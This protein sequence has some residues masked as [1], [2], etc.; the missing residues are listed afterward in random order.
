MV[1]GLLIWTGRARVSNKVIIG[2]RGSKLALIQADSVA[3]KIREIRPD[4][5]VIISKVV[6][7]GDRNPRARLD[8]M[9]GVGVFVKELEEALLS[10]KIDLAVHSLK[11]MPT[12]TPQ[13][14]CLAAITERADP[15]DV[16]VCGA[17]SLAGMPA[18]S[19]IGTGSPRR[20][21]QLVRYR[22]DLE[23]RSIRGNIDTRL[24]KVSHGDYDGVIIAAAAMLRLG[25]QDRISEYLPP[26]Y[27]LPAVGQGALV[28]EARLGDEELL[29]IA[30]ALNHLSAWQSACAERAFLSVLGGGCRAPIAAL[31]TV[32]EDSLQI[33]GMVADTSGAEM[34]RASEKGKA[35]SAEE[36][37]AKLAHEMLAMGAS[38]LI[39]EVKA[40]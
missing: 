9:P 27:F 24:N 37:G 35:T 34:L 19:K 3:A 25:W 29:E 38:E 4:C 20:A 21:V 33:T 30:S 40:G 26:E 13:E 10:G 7:Q 6:T 16:L 39:N 14:L 36:I 2:S 31:A 8:F 32:K 15:R 11:D 23:T 18:G 5:E 1:K 28:I 17:G 12:E 22:P